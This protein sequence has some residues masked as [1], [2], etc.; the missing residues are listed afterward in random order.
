[1]C[2]HSASC[3]NKIMFDHACSLLLFLFIAVSPSVQLCAPD[4]TDVDPGTKVRDPTDCTRYYV[5][6]DVTGDGILLPS[7]PVDCPDAHYFN[8]HHTS[9]RCD[10]IAGA[11][12]DFCSRLC[13]PCEPHCSSPGEL[14]PHPTKCYQYYVCLQNN[15]LLGE[16]CPTHNINFD[17]LT[18]KCQNDDT[19]CYNYCNICEPH[20]T[21]D[22]ERVPD[23]TDCHRFYLCTPPTMSNF[24]C[25]HNQVFSRVTRECEDGATCVVDCP[26]S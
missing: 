4:C 1:M 11:P 24:L 17:Y 20:C 10:P 22:S 6:L 25:P 12:S 23:P 7:E 21:Q 15:N 26:S 9:P 13:N 3:N 19:L 8:E 5:C 14:T 16:E 18:G 2:T